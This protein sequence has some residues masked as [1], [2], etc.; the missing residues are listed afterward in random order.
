MV[1]NTLMYLS[2]LGIMGYTG[3]YPSKCDRALGDVVLSEA[4]AGTD[5][6]KY[7]LCAREN[8]GARVLYVFDTENGT[9][10]REQEINLIA[11]DASEGIL[12]G[13]ER[14]SLHA[15]F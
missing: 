10:I 12:L 14:K 6:R 4:A 2:E 7:F 1:G 11:F 8:G 5:G 13:Q 3:G 15:I 9:W